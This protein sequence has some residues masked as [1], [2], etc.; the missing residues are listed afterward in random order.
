MRSHLPI[1]PHNSGVM[2]RLGRGKTTSNAILRVK[3]IPICSTIDVFVTALY[4]RPPLK[5]RFF[6]GLPLTQGLATKQRSTHKS[7]ADSCHC[8]SNLLFSGHWTFYLQSLN[9]IGEKK[10]KA[11]FLA[12]V[13]SAVTRQ[14]SDQAWW[15]KITAKRVASYRRCYRVCVVVWCNG[16]GFSTQNVL[17][18]GSPARSRQSCLPIINGCALAYLAVLC[19]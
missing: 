16:K 5:Y 1:V 7:L 6:Q 17:S 9:L 13:S 11:N 12:S 19:F 15:R 4:P 2:L 14:A 8:Y 18:P 3:S 10:A